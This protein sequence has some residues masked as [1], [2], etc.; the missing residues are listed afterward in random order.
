MAIKFLSDID[1]TGSYNL[2]ASDIPDISAT[3]ATV[4]WV[5][6][7]NFLTT[8]PAHNH[9]DRYYT[10]SQA[11]GKYLLIGGETD[12]VFVA[13]PAYGVTAQKITNW[14]SAFGWGDHSGAGYLL[15]PVADSYYQPIGNYDNYSSWNL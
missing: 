15:K 13:H 10:K 5:T 9:D 11:D 3:Y 12:P 2:Q 4:A 1:V 8:L 14:D 6:N 7:Q